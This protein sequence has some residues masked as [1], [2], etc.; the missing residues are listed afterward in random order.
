M[1]G[2]I[3]QPLT[4]STIVTG[5]AASVSASPGFDYTSFHMLGLRR[6]HA[7]THRGNVLFWVGEAVPR[8]LK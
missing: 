5:N 6:S 1:G 8:D 2:W 4:L 7:T 3:S